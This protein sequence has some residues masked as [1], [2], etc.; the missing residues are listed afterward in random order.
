[1]GAHTSFMTHTSVDYIIVGQG[2]AGTVMTATLLER[3]AQVLLLDAPEQPTASLAAAGICNPITGRRLVRTWM[4]DRLFPVLH[5]FYA[6]WGNLLQAD[7]YM[8]KEVYRT[9]DS[10]E[11]QNSWYGQSAE[12]GWA[13]FVDSQTDDSRYSPYIANPLGGW[14]TRQGAYVEVGR[15]LEAFRQYFQQQGIYQAQTFD[16][17]AL[18]WHA[19]RPQWQGH[20][21]KALIFC[22]GAALVHNPFFSWLP[23]R[24]NKGE[25]LEITLPA[26]WPHIQPEEVINKG[27]FMLPLGGHRWRIGATYDN[28]DDSPQTTNH[29]RQELEAKLA[30]TFKPPYTVV[31][32]AAGLRPTTPDRRPLVGVHPQYPHLALLNGLG[33]KGLS[34]APYFAA[35]LADLLIHQKAIEPAADLQRYANKYFTAPTI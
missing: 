9:F 16:Y 1:M 19:G 20:Q 4:A 3:G 25:W 14:Q 24:P 34:L 21:A 30:Q 13:A 11:A 18:Q 6:R 27:F 29:A 23:I 35:Q 10:V 33:T 31:A 5:D 32:Q 7:F 17:A 26:D 28:Q 22:E 2:I 12:R 8:P 15:M